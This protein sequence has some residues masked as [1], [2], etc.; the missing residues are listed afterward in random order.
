MTTLLAREIREGAGEILISS[1]KAF[2][3]LWERSLD[4]RPI[5]VDGDGARYE[6]VFP[7]VRNQ[8][9]GPDFLG[10][11]LKRDGETF[12][13][14]VELHLERS[15]WRAHGHHRDPAY[16]G[17][18]LQ[19]VLRAG[20]SAARKSDPPT[21]TATFP[22]APAGGGDAGATERAT[23]SDSELEELGVRRFLSKSAGFRLELDAGIA[24]DQVL[25]EGMMEAMG[26]PRNR[27]P[28]LALAKRVP[29]SGF[30]RV[31]GE[32]ESAARFAVFA[33]LAVGGGLSERVEPRERG[34]ARR[35]ARRMG[36]RRQV[37]ADEWSMFRVRPSGS[38]V[39]RMRGI[40]DIVVRHLED[41]LAEGMRSEFERGGAASVVK[42]LS[43]GAGVGRQ[44]A[45]TVASNIV[46]PALC[47]M[48]WEAAEPSAD[49]IVA[50]FRRMPSPP[51]NSV[52]RSVAAILGA[53]RSP[54]NAAQHSGLHALARA[55]SWPRDSTDS[56]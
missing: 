40:A 38:P 53:R 33:A 7:G 51:Q 12:G 8:G 45:L 11:V 32:P 15:G 43:A 26:Y 49:D 6:V 23:V 16:N 36:V 1:E 20:G 37:R 50:A 14:D 52:T 46:L 28:F 17:V 54:A 27:K 19:V 31:R 35:V 22:E 41:G 10:A 13:G 44:L 21:A 25:Y 4:L 55:A 3:D 34:Q 2:S 29:V 18:A 5:V 56:S 9:P 30:A 48:A 24:P 39:N 47:A 42:S